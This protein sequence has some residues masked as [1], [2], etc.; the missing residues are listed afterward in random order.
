MNGFLIHPRA[1]A[2][3]I[4]QANED[5]EGILHRPPSRLAALS[6]VMRATALGMPFEAMCPALFDWDMTV[7]RQD[8]YAIPILAFSPSKSR[9]LELRGGRAFRHRNTPESL[10]S[11]RIFKSNRNW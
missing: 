11:A 5:T 2:N 9:S 4:N 6:T 1:H 7:I 3:L 8:I 10:T